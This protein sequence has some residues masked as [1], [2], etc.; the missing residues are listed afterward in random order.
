MA[1]K[2]TKAKGAKGGLMGKIAGLF[3]DR[4]EE[5][6]PAP[7][8]KRTVE[9]LSVDLAD[10]DEG[11]R[12]PSTRLNVV[13]KLWGEGYIT[14]GGAEQVK[15]LLPLLAL[16]GKKSVLLLG[17]GLGGINETMVSETGVWVT[18]LESDRELAK[19]GHASMQRAHL[20]RQAPVHYSTMETL[21][22][23]PKSFDAVLSFEATTTIQ[24]KKTLFAAVCDS[25][26]VSGELMFTAF[27]LPNTNPPG[28]KVKAWIA[29]EPKDSPP[30]PWPAEAIQGLLGTLN[31]DVRPYDDIT[32]EYRNWVM[33][34]FLRFLGGISK[35]ELKET[36]QEVMT[37]VEYWTTRLAAIDAG[38]LIVCRFHGIKRPD[39][40]KSLKALG[41]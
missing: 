3:G 31:M 4:A 24:D 7:A 35:A 25:L 34:G 8:P 18:G 20:K 12:W 39:Q 27:A 26:R 15:K 40:R 2:E 33:A 9:E 19:L 17:A 32:L 30:R 41:G 28:D 11:K 14:P 36:A 21:E 23:K 37:E 38:E 16:D 29:T 5:D 22:L 13:E 1:R 6:L 10:P